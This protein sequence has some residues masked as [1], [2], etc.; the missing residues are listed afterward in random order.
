MKYNYNQAKEVKLFTRRLDQLVSKRPVT[1][2]SVQGI[3]FRY[4]YMGL[5]SEQ[6][7]GIAGFPLTSISCGTKSDVRYQSISCFRFDIRHRICHVVRNR[8]L[9]V[10]EKKIVRVYLCKI[11]GN[12]LIT[13]TNNRFLIPTSTLT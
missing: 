10:F 2:D 4:G 11:N 5:K 13:E 3:L 1:L 9:L 12:H 7:S 6:I 8:N